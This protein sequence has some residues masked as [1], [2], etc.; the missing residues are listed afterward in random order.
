MA[1]IHMRGED[2]LFNSLWYELESE[3]GRSSATM[4]EYM[5]SKLRNLKCVG[6]TSVKIVEEIES[7]EIQLVF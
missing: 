6:R 2:I 1:A 4:K 5:S 3:Y 7:F